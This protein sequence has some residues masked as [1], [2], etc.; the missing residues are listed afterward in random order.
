M[1]EP[2]DTSP[3]C[4]N[5]DCGQPLLLVREGRTLCAR[6]E[7]AQGADPFRWTSSSG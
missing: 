2:A 5:P 4:A 6:C 3:R 7:T 1:D